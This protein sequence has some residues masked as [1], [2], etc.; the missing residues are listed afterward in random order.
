MITT[1]RGQFTGSGMILMFR[2]SVT[3]ASPIFGVFQGQRCN[4]SLRLRDKWQDSHR[5]TRSEIQS[6]GDR[7]ED[8]SWTEPQAT[9][10]KQPPENGSEFELKRNARKYMKIPESL[11]QKQK[12]RR[13]TRNISQ[14]Y[15]SLK[16]RAC[17]AFE[18]KPC[19]ILMGT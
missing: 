11:W 19:K 15:Q 13:W 7:K 6:S 5:V 8:F 9:S 17:G 18:M 10:T 3:C 1:I 2:I 4:K 14:F 16:L 12:T